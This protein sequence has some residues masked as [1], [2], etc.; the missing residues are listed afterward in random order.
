VAVPPGFRVP[1]S[2]VVTVW[3]QSLSE[4]NPKLIVLIVPLSIAPFRGM[5]LFVLRT[6]AVVRVRVSAVT[7]N[8]IT[9][10]VG[11]FLSLVIGFPTYG[12]MSRKY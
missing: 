1:T 7:T 3:V 6:A 12:V 11:I 8:A 2:K 10:A 4:Y 9:A 5:V